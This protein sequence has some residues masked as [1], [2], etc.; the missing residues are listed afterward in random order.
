[1]LSIIALSSSILFVLTLAGA[2]IAILTFCFKNESKIIELPIFL[3]ASFVAGFG[4]SAFSASLAYSF[5]GISYY[6]HILFFITTCLWA[7]I[8]L[9]RKQLNFRIKKVNGFISFILISTSM[10][11]LLGLRSK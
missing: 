7:S 11:F 9:I 6:F 8:Y 2:P 1:M 5:L 10:A 4:I 3:A